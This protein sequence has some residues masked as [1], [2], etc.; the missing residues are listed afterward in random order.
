MGKFPK[1]SP[2]E[3]PK[4]SLALKWTWHWGTEGLSEEQLA[5][6]DLHAARYVRHEDSLCSVQLVCPWVWGA[7]F[8]TEICNYRMEPDLISCSTIAGCLDASLKVGQGGHEWFDL[9]G[10]QFLCA[11]Y[12]FQLWAWHVTSCSQHSSKQ[13]E[14]CSLDS[15]TSSVQLYMDHLSIVDMSSTL[16]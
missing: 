3:V 5:Q 12:H 9:P 13:V 16:A 1:R 4:E 15:S 8:G 14:E 2:E 10:A 7:C 11:I 6:C